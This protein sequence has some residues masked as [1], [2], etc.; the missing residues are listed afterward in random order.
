MTIT[1]AELGT[2]V[3]NVQREWKTPSRAVPFLVIWAGIAVT[4]LLMLGRDRL[5]LPSW[6]D[7]AAAAVGIGF[8]VA[9]ARLATR[10]TRA[11]VER[12][13]VR[14]VSCGQPLIDNA[15]LAERGTSVAEVALATGQCRRCG[16]AAFVV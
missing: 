14:C 5:Q 2:A 10:R 6:L 13:Q 16:K 3:G 9:A 12:H 7:G 8:L 11:I 15:V 1:R 4:V